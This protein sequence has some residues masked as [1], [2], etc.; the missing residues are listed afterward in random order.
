MSATQAGRRPRLL[1]V[2]DSEGIG[3][4]ELYLRTLLA[5]AD[6]EAYRVG[7]L[8]PPRAALRPL[9]EEA[10]ARGAGIFFLDHV[11]HE[12]L[13]A[14]AVLRATAYLRMLRPAIVHFVLPSPRRS[15]EAIVAA[16]LAGIPRRLAT[17]QLVTPVPRFGRITGGLRSINRQLQYRTLH[18][19]I[20]VSAGNMRLL[21]EQYGFPRT[22]LH[23]IPN[24]VNL[25]QFR[26]QPA[27]GGLR[28]SWGVPDGVRLLGVVGRLSRQKGH[29]V[30][31]E[32]LPLIWETHAD[33]HVALIGAGELEPELRERA[34][35]IDPL[36]RIHFVGQQ[37]HMPAAL[38]ALDLFA[39]PSLY[40]GL[41]FAVLEA[42]AME[43]PIVATAVDGV[44]EVIEDGRTGLLVPPGAPQPL[45]QAIVRLIE[46]EGLSI[47][48][49]RA[50]R[51]HV[52]RS[53]DQKRMIANTFALYR[54]RAR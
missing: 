20:A 36:G 29:L 31:F 18:H 5:H 8:V 32:A 6:A 1:Y 48:L 9:V 46:D 4:A 50:A 41:P 12:G 16:V 43:L 52:T 19:G 28:A 2:T 26:P 22:R 47:R 14:A 54:Q 38:A 7:L 45:A 13:G 44:A 11:H 24:G 10:R 39:L 37:E 17:F 42:M 53:F 27:G 51:A 35:R 3:G 40:E 34:A 21:V 30:L 25:E 49:R 23:L 33:L 15:A